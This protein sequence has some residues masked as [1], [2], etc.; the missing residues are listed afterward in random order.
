MIVQTLWF[1]L[2]ISLAL[3]SFG[4]AVT[5]HGE[6]DDDEEGNFCD[7]ALM[8]SP[9]SSDPLMVHH[10]H[11]P[12]DECNERSKMACRNLCVALAEA[13]RN[14]GSGDKIFCR[15]MKK[16]IKATLH[17][18]S[19]VCQDDFQHTGISYIEPLCC[20]DGNVVDCS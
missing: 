1:Y 9:A 3:I 20:R 5:T 16:E 7:C 10:F 14:S 2:L 12:F 6:H 4:G 19:K 18:F 8:D 15:L 17:V 11:I 13:G